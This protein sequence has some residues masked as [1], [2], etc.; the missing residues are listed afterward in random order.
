[1]Q[2][3]NAIESTVALR[4]QVGQFVRDEQALFVRV[5]VA[6]AGE[7]LRDCNVILAR[8]DSSFGLIA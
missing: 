8:H 2:E 7:N 1:L 3:P 6:S 5:N 4:E